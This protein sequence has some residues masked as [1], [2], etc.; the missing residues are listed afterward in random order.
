MNTSTPAPSHKRAEGAR[1]SSTPDHE[2]LIIGSGFAGLCM[3][4]QLRKAGIESFLIFEKGPD[5]GG[6]WRVN[7]YPGCAC[8]IPSHLYSY[9]F[10]LNANWSRM[11]PTQPE[12]WQY[13]RDTARKHD[14]YRRV[15]FNVEVREAV[16]DERDRLWRV[17]T[18]D[19]DEVTGRI[20]ISGM[21][22][23]SRPRYPA[24]PGLD[25]FTG[26]SFHS[27]EWNHDID[28]AGKRVGVVGTGASAIQFVPQIAREADRLVLLQRS[29]PWVLPKLDRPIRGWERSLFR[30]LPGYMRAFRAWLFWRQESVALGYTV[31]PKLLAPVEKWGRRHL[32]RTIPD[33]ELRQRVTPDYTVGCKRTLL[34]NDYLPALAR[35][36]VDV[37]T[38]HLT[39]IR[40]RSLATADGREHE[41]DVLIFAT[42]FDTLDLTSPVRFVGSDGVPLDERWGNSPE[43]YH[44]VA[45]NGYPNLFFIIGPNSRVAN[46]SI[47][48][49]IEAQVHYVIKCIEHMNREGATAIEATAERQRSY[50]AE[51]QERMQKTVFVSG[52][53]NWYRSADGRNPILWPGFAFRYWMRARTV[54]PEAY[55]L[56]R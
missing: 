19:G 49:M 38:D 4:I 23:L 10:E 40:E 1:E 14:I 47:V 35:D 22:G 25:S 12:I 43:A 28:L 51:L 15:R 17:R 18:S 3:A 53:R 13:L 56:T 48:F 7:T 21:G 39:E 37:I 33:P 44:G 32:A 2:V 16:Y 11:Y 45:V 34:S 29:P 26:P 24:V 50:N 46:N 31:S 9:S 8:D 20:L 41:V 6:T 42:G 52:C 54:E 27:S 30:F 5:V 36:N 55:H